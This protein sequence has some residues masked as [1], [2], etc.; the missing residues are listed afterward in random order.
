M[1]KRLIV[2]LMMMCMA[3]IPMG[4]LAEEN[5]SKVENDMDISDIKKMI[6]EN[7]VPTIVL[8]NELKQEADDLYEG[9]KYLEASEAYHTAAKEAQVL[10]NIM[11][12]CYIPHNN[13]SQLSIPEGIQEAVSG[14]L[15]EA[16]KLIRIRNTCIVYEGICYSRMGDNTE[17]MSILYDALDL[18]SN[19]E[20]STWELAVNEIIALIQYDP[21]AENELLNELEEYKG[22]PFSEFV[23]VYGEANESSEAEVSSSG[24]SYIMY[25]FDDFTV[26]TRID[27]RGDETVNEVWVN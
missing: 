17:A 12:Q 23:K 8:I 24:N 25:T 19:E 22:K 20:Q 11:G 14:M 1:R 21:S 18:I 3:V 16:V 2:L 7:G 26:K 15:E 10:A 6:E 9:E 5:G 4:V 27:F 13:G